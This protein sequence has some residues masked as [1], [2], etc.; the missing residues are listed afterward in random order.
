MSD[1]FEPYREVARRSPP[2]AR[3]A[4]IGLITIAQANVSQKTS[5]NDAEIWDT[6]PRPWRVEEDWTAEVTDGA[7]EII[8][9]LPLQQLWLAQFIVRSMLIRFSP[10]LTSC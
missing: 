9:K 5:S 3:A 1:I 8:V 10:T 4:I 2:D 7:G 6:H